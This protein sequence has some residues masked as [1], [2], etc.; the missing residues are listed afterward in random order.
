MKEVGLIYGGFYVYFGFCDVFLV[1]VEVKVC[2]DFVVLVV[3]VVA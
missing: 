2:V 1:E 3:C